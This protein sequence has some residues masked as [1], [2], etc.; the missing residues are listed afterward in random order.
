MTPCPYSS[1]SRSGQL[2]R[3]E[4]RTLLVNGMVLDPEDARKGRVLY[5]YDATV[6]GELSVLSD[7]V[8]CH[9]YHCTHLFILIHADAHIV[10]NR[11]R[12]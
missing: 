12:R 10:P 9:Y 1:S 11:W 6:D 3:E 4:K 5:D 8:T 7:Q 2:T